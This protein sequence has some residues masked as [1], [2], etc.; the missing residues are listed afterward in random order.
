M[1]KDLS[2]LDDWF[3]GKWKK[4]K[5]R[6]KGEL[7]RK[8]RIQAKGFKVVIEE[9]KQRVSAKSE[10]LRRYR[11]RGN[12]YRQNNFFRCNQKALYKEI[13]KKD[14]HKFHLMQKNRKNSGVNSGIVLS[15]TKRILNG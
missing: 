7:R 12:Q 6:Q 1:K 4:D 11:T 3:Q 13:E 2:P 14:I 8:Y 5:K 9:L 10:T 15:N